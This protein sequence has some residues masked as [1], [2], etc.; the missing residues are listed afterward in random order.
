M[1]QAREVIQSMRYTTFG[2]R[3]GLRVSEFALGTANFGTNWGAGAEFEDS[4]AMFDTFAEAGGT[5]I[6]TADIYQFGQSETYLADLISTD[7]EHFVLASKFTQGDTAQ[8]HV[9]KTGNSRKVMV[10]ALEKSLRRLGTDYLDLYWVHWPD[11]VTPIEEIV[12]TVDDLVRAGKILHAGFSNFPAWRTAHA[13][14][15]ADERGIGARI[16]GVQTEYS[17]VERTADREIMPMAEA[18]G[19]GVALYSPLGGGL[20]TGKYRT[21]DEGRLTTLGAVIQREDTTRKSAV[22]DAVLAVAGEIGVSPAQVAMSWQREHARR[23]AT[24]VVPIIGPRTS[25]QLD[26]YLASLDVTLEDEQY[27]RLTTASDP[28]LGAPHDGAARSADAVRGRV[29]GDFI[30]NT[31]VA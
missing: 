16:V 8:P 4:R 28:S 5:F 15:L 3:T 27:T 14:T 11:F 12:E 10:Q 18:F 30:V 2:R 24:A 19:L 22:V 25:A 13:A 20:L 1:Q 26:D 7:R 17:L 31:P 29:G 6:D 23:R 21:S 9:S